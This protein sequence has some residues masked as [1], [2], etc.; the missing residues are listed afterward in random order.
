MKLAKD[1]IVKNIVGNT[2]VIPIGQ[3]YIDGMK[4]LSL[5][6]EGTFFVRHIIAG[7]NEEQILD[8]YSDLF[9][10][11]LDIAREKMENFLSYGREKGFIEW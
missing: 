4:I 2:V 8:L 3:A 10:E 7:K 1:Y 11:D 9:S 6:T 5:D